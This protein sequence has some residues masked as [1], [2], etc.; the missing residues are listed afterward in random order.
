MKLVAD[1]HTHTIASGHAYSTFEEMVDAAREKGLQ[2]IAITDHG[3]QMPGAPDLDYFWNTLIW[4]REVNDVQVLRGVETN[5]I[6]TKGRLDIPDDILESLDIVLAGFHHGTG[7]QGST[8]EENTQAMVNALQNPLVHIIVHPGNPK[9]PID[10][11]RVVHVARENGKALEINNSTFMGIR[12]QS[13]QPCLRIAKLAEQN[14]VLL[15]VN[16][17]AHICYQVGDCS[18][19]MDVVQKAGIEESNILNTSVELIQEFLS[20]H[21]KHIL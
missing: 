1:L 7:Y 18:L 4:P 3:S 20:R 2:M 8:V 10:Y 16:S 21:G 17:D 12:P 6:D 19:A 9:F 14:G 15:A 5:I 11:E 13:Y